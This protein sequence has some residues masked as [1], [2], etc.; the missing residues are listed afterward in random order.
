MVLAR[1]NTPKFTP[2]VCILG[3]ALATGLALAQDKKQER[4]DTIG[5]V[6]DPTNVA[7]PEAGVFVSPDDPEAAALAQ[8]GSRLIERV[9]GLLVG[10]VNRELANKEVVE[11]IDA[12]HLKQLELPKTTPGQPKVTAIRRTSLMLRD[13]A[14]TPDAA[15]LA[16]MERIHQQL[17][18]NEAPDKVIVQKIERKDQPVEWR[19]SRPIA[20]TQSCLACHGDPAKFA[21]AVREVI[22]RRYP[23]DKAIDYSK[24]EYRGVLRVSLLAPE[25]AK[26]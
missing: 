18:N 21:P 11:A 19:V 20:T 6:A 25:P 12:M 8:F 1:M 15:D 9:G 13:P 7:K 16:A 2:V 22:E 3:V 17:M 5:Y 23:S 4:P 26:Q 10:E 24:Q 14:N